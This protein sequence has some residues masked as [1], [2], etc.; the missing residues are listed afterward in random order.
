[1][2]GIDARASNRYLPLVLLGVL[3]I[4]CGP[5]A[6]GAQPAAA[7]PSVRI[8]SPASAAQIEGDTI[9][10]SLEV[11][12][13]TLAALG[14][15]NKPREGHI[16]VTLNSQLQMTDKTTVTFQGVAPGTH[17]LEAE[18][19]NNDHSPLSPPVRQQITFTTTLP[20]GAQPAPEAPPTYDYGY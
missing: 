10:V 9:S 5:G 20:A 12:D 7:S 8:L 14:S 16:H 18:L 15:S 17:Q 13:F 11:R 4:A 2:K 3:F 1:M 19:V 6:T